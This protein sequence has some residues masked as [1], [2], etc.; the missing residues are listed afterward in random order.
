[1]RQELRKDMFNGSITLEL[2]LEKA[3]LMVIASCFVFVPLGIW[4]AAEIIIWIYHKFFT[5]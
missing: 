1:M 5:A 2:N 4:K 3:L